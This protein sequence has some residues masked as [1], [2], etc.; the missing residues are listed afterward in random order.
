MPLVQILMY[1]VLGIALAISLV[2]DVRQQMIYDVVTYPAIVLCL[3]LRLI[4]VGWRGGPNF[5]FSLLSG[6]IGFAIG[7]GLFFLMFIMGGMMGGDVKLMGAVGAALGLSWDLIY[8]MM[9]IALVG[10]LE[11]ILFLLW[12]G[13]LIQT[14]GNLGK[15]A[16]HH[17]HLKRLEGPEP[18]K[19]YVP[20]GVAIALGTVWAVVQNHVAP[21]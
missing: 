10:G 8:G 14:F 19:K 9:C 4:L 1:V 2:T 17:L 3:A 18:E 6:L 7:F 15:K 16:L 11:A 5:Q 12:E 13:S 20:Y 21:R